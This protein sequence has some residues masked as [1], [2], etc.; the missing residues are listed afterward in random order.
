MQLGEIMTRDV[1]VVGLEA[2]L[3]VAA[4]LMK[5]LDVGM[6][7]VC[8]GKTLKG[9][10]TDRD[11]TVRAT[12]DGCDP[13]STKVCDIMSTDIAYCFEDQEIEEAMSLME[14]QQIRRLPVL[15]RDKRLVG[16]VSLGDLAVHSGEKEMVGDTLKEVSRPA[17]PRR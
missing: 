12:A 11:I 17:I 15:S 7:P 14:A 1:E 16:I 2:P 10:I 8:D 6:V 13:A 9:T 4:A 5:S 3:Q